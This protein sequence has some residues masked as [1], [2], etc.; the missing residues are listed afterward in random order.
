MR[1][2]SPAEMLGAVEDLFHAHFENDVG[3]RADPRPARSDV[4]QQRVERLAR[5]ALVDRID[6]DEHAI[7]AEQLLAHLIREVFVID[8]RLG[9]DAYRG[10]LFENTVEAVVLWRR[11]FP[12]CEIATPKNCDF[13]AFLLRHHCILQEGSLQIDWSGQLETV[14]AKD[15][16]DG[17]RFSISAG[18]TPPIAAHVRSGHA[19]A[20]PRESASLSA[21]FPCVRARHRSLE[22][23][24]T[25]PAPQA[26]S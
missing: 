9:T 5:L 13:K 18:A 24:D 1:V 22:T 19:A 20:G 17:S 10:E 6:P 15:Q 16:A 3:M 7:G 4:A 12:R 23:W 2:R 21:N 8:G 25:S 14:T 26:R 11:S